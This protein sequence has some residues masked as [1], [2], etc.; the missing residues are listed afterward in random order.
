MQSPS[1]ISQEPR[2]ER[3]ES[4]K[5]SISAFWLLPWRVALIAAFAAALFLALISGERPLGVETGKP[6]PRDYVARVD[7][8]SID[9]R[10][11]EAAEET[12]SGKPVIYKNVEAG[13]IIVPKGAQVG[14]QHL[15]DLRKETEQFRHSATGRRVRLQENAGLILILLIILAGGVVYALRYRTELFH[16]RLRTL[17]FVL[18]TLLV[19]GLAR[20]C[21]TRSPAIT[22]LWTPIPMVVMIMCLVYDQRFGMA[23]TVF[24]ALLVRL[25][26][27]AADE[28]FVVLLLGGMMAALLTRH[29]R[30]RSAL[31][32]VGFMVGVLQFLAVWGMGLFKVRL[33]TQVPLAFWESP[34][35]IESLAALANGFLSGFI[36]SG[37]LPAIERL[38]EVTT[39][40]RLLEWSDPNQPLLQKLLLKAPGS[41]HHSMLVGSLAADAAESIG[42]NPLLARVSSYFHDI[43]KMKKPQYFAENFPE[44]GAN[45][46]D[47]LTPTM[48]SLIITAHPKDGAEMASNSG[49]P[50]PV[51]DIIL[52]SHGSGVVRCF[53]EKARNGDRGGEQVNE[54]DFRYRLPKPQSKEAAIVMLADAVESAA[55][56]ME[57]PLPDR[58]HNMVRKRIMERLSDGQLDESGLTITDLKRL[59]DS[60]VHT[61]AAIFHN[62]IQYPG[63]DEVEERL[64]AAAHPA[65]GQSDEDRDKQ[66]AEQG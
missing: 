20:M 53:W 45:P 56:S 8:T 65:E 6:A 29:V 21:V 25:A 38:F 59:E 2:S 52:Q 48:S 19:V 60:F 47:E 50:K 16:Q 27:P 18:L 1:S 66:S 62:R 14:P 61:I 17:S 34:L 37:I 42:A 15:E 64:E 22:L 3:D 32:K 40:I 7:F 49:V 9:V 58:L 54:H 35:F 10:R 30:T 24:Y 12:A 63:Q 5:R 33:Q 43:G 23:V 28:A 26:A 36:V 44:D 55:R 39:D 51:Q 57:N 31:V 13:Q 46:H 41:Y 11:T 4:A